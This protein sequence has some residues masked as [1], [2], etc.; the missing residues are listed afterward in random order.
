M[1]KSLHGSI[2]NMLDQYIRKKALQRW[3]LTN[4]AILSAGILLLGLGLLFNELMSLIITLI[5]KFIH[6]RSSVIN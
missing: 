6:H 2:T 5:W 1:T 3:G 4:G